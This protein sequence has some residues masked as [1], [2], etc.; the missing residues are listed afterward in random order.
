MKLSK[1]LFFLIA[2]IF[3]A[4]VFSVIY[5]LSVGGHYSLHSSIYVSDVVPD[6]YSVSYEHEDVVKLTDFRLDDTD[7]DLGLSEVV[8]EFDAI[9][10]GATDV[11]ITFHTLNDDG[12]IF[13]DTCDAQLTVNSAGIILE[14]TRHTI[15]FQSYQ[16]L[17]YV[18]MI[19]L[20]AVLLVMLLLFIEYIKKDRKSVV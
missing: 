15:N 6:S 20:A 19:V 4:I 9:T 10:K 11:R 18:L 2:F 17:L 7:P 1:K 16:V 14:T 5:T 8:F 3:A 12:T 13:R